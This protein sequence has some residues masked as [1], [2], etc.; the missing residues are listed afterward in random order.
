MQRSRAAH[1]RAAVNHPVDNE[2]MDACV[3]DCFVWS[4]NVTRGLFGDAGESDVEL[5]PKVRKE[6]DRR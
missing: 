2:M 3:H 6:L 1:A 5:H 4:G